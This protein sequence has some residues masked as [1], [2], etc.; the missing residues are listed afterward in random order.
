MAVNKVNFKL[1]KAGIVGIIG[2]NGAGKTTLFNCITG[3]YKPISGQIFYKDKEITG[4]RSYEIARLGICRTFQNIRLFKD[5][6]VL[7]NVMTAMHTKTSTNLIDAIFNTKRYRRDE[8]ATLAKSEEVLRLVG[9]FDYRFE[10]STNLPYGSQRK[11]EIARA[12]ASGADVLLFDEPAAGMNEQETMELME[13]IVRLHDMGYSI[14]L[15]EHDMRLVM[16][17]CQKI[18]V[19]NHGMLIAEGCA[20]E[21]KMN[22]LVIEAYLGKEVC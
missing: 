14:L 1:E 16:N 12:I 13:F 8:E 10:Y 18:Y 3:I 4:F 19:L 21:I 9:L 2:P 20:D 17:V 6:T 7:E 11:L 5:M 22:E 15:I